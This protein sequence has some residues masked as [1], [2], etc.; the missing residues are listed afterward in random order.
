MTFDEALGGLP[1]GWTFTH[2]M[3]LDPDGFQ[4]NLINHED[5]VVVIGTGEFPVEAVAKASLNTYD[6]KNFMPL[7]NPRDHAS[8]SV[9]R[10]DNSID[11]AKLFLR[12]EP[13]GRRL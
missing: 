6:S 5:G 9:G 4:C 11:I 13:I 2:L 12:R 10:L 8:P 1:E 3:A 7:Y